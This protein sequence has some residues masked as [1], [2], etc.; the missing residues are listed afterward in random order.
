M[1][2]KTQ[3]ATFVFSATAM[4]QLSL[5]LIARSVMLGFVQKTL[6]A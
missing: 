6:A 3:F 1:T 4:I 5:V 2:K